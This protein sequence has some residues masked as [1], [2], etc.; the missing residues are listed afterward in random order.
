V[1]VDHS[2]HMAELLCCCTKLKPRRLVDS[3]MSSQDT[4]LSGHAKEIGRRKDNGIMNSKFT[5]HT[6]FLLSYSLVFYDLLRGICP[7]PTHIWTADPCGKLV[8]ENATLGD[9][10]TRLFNR[11]LQSNIASKPER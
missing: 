3:I 4:N 2:M 9:G 7:S 5:W 6:V 1:G 10:Y 8:L 11:L